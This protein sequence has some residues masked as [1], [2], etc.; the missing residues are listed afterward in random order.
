MVRCALPRAISSGRGES[1]YSGFLRI[2]AS[3]TV[4]R[5]AFGT[6]IPTSDFP[7]I[8]ASIRIVL[9]LRASWSSCCRATIREMR[10][11]CAGWGLE[12]LWL[13]AD[14]VDRRPLEPGHD[15]V[16]TF[17]VDQ[18]FDARQPVEDD[19]AVTTFHCSSVYVGR[20]AQPRSFGMRTSL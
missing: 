18:V 7:G 17:L 20:I 1:V 8:G 6:S 3:P 13:R 5:T 4:E 14:A 12:Q 16:S 2:E 9:A 15:E 10:T 19:A 11:P